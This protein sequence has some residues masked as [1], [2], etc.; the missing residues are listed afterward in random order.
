MGRGLPPAADPAAAMTVIAMRWG[1]AA[2][3]AIA[4]GHVSVAHAQPAAQ[5]FFAGKQINLICGAA[6][7]GGYDALA[8]LLGRHLGRLIGGNPTVIV[9]NM[10]A[11]GSL[12]ATNLIA[13]TAPKDGL[14]I[15]L[16]QRGMLLTP[17][18]NPGAV[19]FEIDKLNWIGSL[20]S[21]VGLAFAWYTSRHKSA[22]DLFEKELIVGG[23]VGVDPELTPRL[24]NAVLGTKFKIV[25][26]YTGTTDI[27]LAIERGEVEGIGDWSWSSLKKQKPD[28]IADR[29]ITLLLQSGLH[30]DPELPDLPNALDF[31]KTD[32]DRKVIE[33]YLTQ[34]QVARPIIAPPGVPAARLAVLRTAFAALARDREFLADAERSGLEVDPIPGEAVDAVVALIASVPRDVADRYRHAFAVPSPAP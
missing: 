16:I 27:G 13:N 7:G 2:I 33:L 4:L 18:V 12:A 11:A 22:R 24:Y 8:R 28:W 25:T 23:H 19:R 17:L 3:V 29:K 1:G 21:E 5:S 34:K 6:V 9:Q 26:G 10:P 32:A 30:N 20:A 15:A 14:T 31:A